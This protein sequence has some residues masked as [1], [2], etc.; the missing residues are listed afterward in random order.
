M[1]SSSISR[2]KALLPKYQEKEEPNIPSDRRQLSMKVMLVSNPI[3]LEDESIAAD[4]VIKTVPACNIITIVALCL[5]TFSL[6]LLCYA[7]HQYRVDQQGE[8][9][10]CKSRWFLFAGTICQV[11]R[12]E[13][14]T[15]NV[16]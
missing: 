11:S 13:V 1:Q 2:L 6:A 14:Q 5:H 9:C 7:L 12:R 16:W 8:I 3:A 15:D 4:T 10:L